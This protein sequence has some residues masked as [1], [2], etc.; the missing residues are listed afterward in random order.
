MKIPFGLFTKNDLQTVASAVAEANGTTLQATKEKI[1]K[2]ALELKAEA[3]AKIGQADQVIA[4]ANAEYQEVVKQ[5]NQK[6]QVA[7]S[8]G[9]SL[10][11]DAYQMVMKATSKEEAISLLS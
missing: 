9:A 3:A 5:A 10:R 11:K 7:A 2:N 8:Q 4:E 1:M 6:M